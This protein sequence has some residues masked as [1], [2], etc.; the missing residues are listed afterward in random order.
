MMKVHGSVSERTIVAF[1]SLLGALAISRSDATSFT[2]FWDSRFALCCP[3]FRHLRHRAL[4]LKRAYCQHLFPNRIA[5]DAKKIVNS[6]VDS[7][8]NTFS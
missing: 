7:H 1:R 5:M 3:A 8:N 4:E 6:F 2:A